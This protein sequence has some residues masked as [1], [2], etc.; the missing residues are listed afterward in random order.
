MESLLQNLR[1]I[2][3]LVLVVG[4][5]VAACGGDSSDTTTTAPASET[6]APS[7]TTSTTELVTTTTEPP[8]TTTTLPDVDTAA[9]LSIFQTYFDKIAVKDYE[10]AR[11]AST[12]AANDYA[13]LTEHLDAISPQPDWQ[14]ESA[15]DPSCC[16]VVPVDG[17]LF[18]AEVALA[19]GEANGG[20]LAVANPVIDPRG[21]S[22]LLVEWGVD[23]GSGVDQAP[24]SARL[25]NL[26]PDFP[27]DPVDP[28]SCNSLPL[29]A[30]VP[31]GSDTSQTTRII[32]MGTMCSSDRDLQPDPNL[33]KLYTDDGSL[34]VAPTTML[35]NNGPEPIP[36]GTTGLFLIIFEV[37]SD[38]LNQNLKVES[39]FKYTDLAAWSI[40]E[41]E[42]GSFDLN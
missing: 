17:G 14:L 23:L 35:W 6:T 24:L 38:Q 42:I 32:V 15:S 13:T 22:P 20:Q 7:E 3:G 8:T 33:T 19:Y 31:G 1:R 40:F 28:N 41:A 10:G 4:L 12:D 27:F 5:I 21:A 37:A 26:H 18:G 29:W 25:K 36:G 39:Q 34:E 16:A 11:E 9:V 30:Y 2:V